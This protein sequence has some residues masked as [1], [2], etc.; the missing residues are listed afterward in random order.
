MQNALITRAGWKKLDDELKYL[1]KIKRPSVTEAV[2][3]AAAL[4]DRSENAEYKEGKRLLR[5]IDRRIRYLSKSLDRLKIV[6]Y[7]PEQE[8]RV[9][10]GAYVTLENEQEELLHCRIVGADEIDPMRQDIS[11]N[12]PM[13]KALLGKAVD[14][15]VVVH[16]PSG[17]KY[18]YIVAIEYRP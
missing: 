6:D 17:D 3:E 2:R 12:S 10:F 18:W 13:S 14:D 8:G 7:S 9:Y 1:W 11:I 5:E 4:G 15:E 16:A